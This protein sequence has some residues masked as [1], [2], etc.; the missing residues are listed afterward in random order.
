M[1]WEITDPTNT[2]R[3]HP[4]PVLV[5]VPIPSFPDRIDYEGILGLNL[6]PEQRDKLF[7]LATPAGAFELRKL[8]ETALHL[9]D[10]VLRQSI[11]R[12]ALSRQVVVLRWA[13]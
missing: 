3:A 1:S 4:T 12:L 8:A 2:V 6:P 13:D 7:I 11:V 5:M 9:D 10:L